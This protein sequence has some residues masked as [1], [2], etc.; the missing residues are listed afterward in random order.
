MDIIDLQALT[1][2][3]GRSNGYLS[4]N[5]ATDQL[6]VKGS[7][8]IGKMV[9]WVRFKFNRNYRESTWIARRKIMAS[10]LSDNT[11]KKDFKKRLSRLDPQGGFFYQDK[12]LS[13]RTVRCF[14]DDVQKNVKAYR[15]ARYARNKNWISWFSG[16]VDTMTS[17]ENFENRTDIMLAEKM[18]HERGFTLDKHEIEG[19]RE[20]VYEEALSNRAAV[21]AIE[22][23]TD[24]LAHVDTAMSRVLDRA[25]AAVRLEAQNRLK[26]QLSTVGLSD[27]HN[28][29]LEAE[30]DDTTIAT[31]SELESRVN[32]LV[33]AQI[34]DEFDEL[35]EQALTHHNFNDKLS[36][37]A[38]VKEQLQTKL[39]EQN[40]YQMLSVAAARRQATQLLGG[41]IQSKQQALAAVKP[42]EFTGA[43]RLLSRLVLQDPYV[44]KVQIESMQQHLNETLEK[45][46]AEDS[47]AYQGLGM[48]KGKFLSKL[49]QFDHPDSLF[50][51]LKELLKQ[52]SKPTSL[53]DD[54]NS[55]ITGVKAVVRNYT[56][57]VAN[58]TAESYTKVSALKG[59]IPEHIYNTLLDRVNKG[60]VWEPE[61]IA[62]ANE[63]YLTILTEDNNRELYRLLQTPQVAQKKIGNKED[64]SSFTL[65]DLLASTP[66]AKGNKRQAIDTVMPEN[67]RDNLLDTLEQQLGKVRDRVMSKEDADALFQREIVNFLRRQQ[68]SFENRQITSDTESSKSGAETFYST[69]L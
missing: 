33:V 47:T 31:T 29:S 65:N 64:F 1:A 32:K 46:Y 63:L 11:Y 23:E 66:S 52:S 20:K 30:I 3:L 22:N 17:D 61:F 53:F 25:I 18:K 4:V 27:T 54:N 9:V 5:R 67:V 19:L 45:M 24:A 42:S 6:E 35:L 41:W 15:L 16:R 58:P 40:K 26:Q 38:V 44:C 28:R 34:G 51:E 57:V 55:Q 43:D 36:Q 8:F 48:D 39:A 56:E 37:L 7:N 10:L 50:N 62:D 21:Q 13:A 2:I 69:P 60:Y 59:K 68:I 49:R 12:P 14:I